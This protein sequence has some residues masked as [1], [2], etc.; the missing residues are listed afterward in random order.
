VILGRSNHFLNIECHPFPTPKIGV[1]ILSIEGIHFAYQIKHHTDDQN[2]CITYGY[3]YSL[4]PDV[5]QNV[6]SKLVQD[7]E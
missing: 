1:T 3:K 5:F 6:M 4:E 7:I 2:L